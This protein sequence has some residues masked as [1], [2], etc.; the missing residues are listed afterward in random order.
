MHKYP[1]DSEKEVDAFLMGLEAVYNP[2]L[3]STG[4]QESGGKW[5]ATFTL[6]DEETEDM[7]EKESQLS[8]LT[9]SMQ[10]LSE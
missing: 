7:E 1:F 9:E 3:T 10:E 8:S 5:L 4:K 2:D 6:K